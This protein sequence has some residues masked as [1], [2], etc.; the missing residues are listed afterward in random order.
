MKAALKATLEQALDD[1][2]ENEAD[3]EQRPAG[4]I[5]EGLHVQMAE[6]AAAVYDASFKAQE[7]VKKNT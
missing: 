1:W 4:Y 2:L 7:W 3:H 6:A 5:Y